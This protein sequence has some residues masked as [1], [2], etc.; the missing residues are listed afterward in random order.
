MGERRPFR[1]QGCAWCCGGGRTWLACEQAWASGI[2][3]AGR[4]R[5][6]PPAAAQAGRG[7]RHPTDSHKLLS[8]SGPGGDGRR[9]SLPARRLGVTHGGDAS[10]QRLSR[11]NLG[12]H[13]AR[14][15]GGSAACGNRT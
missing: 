4:I 12:Y 1:V 13:A 5:G 11:P 6:R 3:A 7:V 14:I 2:S 9:Q 8:R 15:A 10:I